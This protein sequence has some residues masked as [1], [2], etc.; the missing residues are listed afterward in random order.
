[1]AVFNI[2][3]AEMAEIITADVEPRENDNGREKGRSMVASWASFA[4][5]RYPP[6]EI[7]DVLNGALEEW[8]K[9]AITQI[10][11]HGM[12]NDPALIANLPKLPVDDLKNASTRIVAL[13]RKQ[14]EAL[15]TFRSQNSV[16]P[17]KYT[18]VP[19]ALLLGRY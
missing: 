13:K 15:R 3:H 18:W 17:K 5:L 10:E 7:V 14:A 8:A 2:D 6:S 19:Q 11:K 1:M 4:Y 9:K 16:D 12:K